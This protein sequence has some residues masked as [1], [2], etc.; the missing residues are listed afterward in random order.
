MRLHFPN[1]EHADVI[2]ASGD[3]T[4]GSAQ[5]NNV[6]VGKPGVAAHHVRLAVAERSIVHSVS[7]AQARVHV[8]ARPVREKA[9]LR[10]GDTVSL[11]T[12]QLRLMPDRD[13][14]I[15]TQVPAGSR[16]PTPASPGGADEMNATRARL[17]PPKVVLRGVSG[18]YF[19]KIVPVRGRLVIGRGADCDLVLDEAEMSRRH[20]VIENSG[21][22]IYLRDLGSANGTFVN[23]V[24]VRDAVL[25]P[26][27]QI[28]FDTNRFLLEAPSLPTRE[29]GDQPAIDVD[30]STITQTMR[31]VPKPVQPAPAKPADERNKND[32]WWLIGAA[33]LIALGIAVL[34][35]VF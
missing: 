33:A 5:D 12:I 17:A 3:I 31:A 25:H 22:G 23:G 2:V 1:K 21:D 20:A 35:Y 7:D 4:I 34:F 14:A 16:N 13:A 11:D 19:G 27:D 28:A 30:H 10:L 29:E 18:S 24:Q 6:V 15:R 26:D 9:L 32:I 8:N